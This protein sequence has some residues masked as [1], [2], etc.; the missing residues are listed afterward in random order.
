[1][2]VELSTAA[3]RAIRTNVGAL[4]LPGVEV[5]AEPVE[6]L[7]SRAPAAAFDVVFCDPPYVQGVAE[8]LEA[9]AG[10]GWLVP[11]AVVVVERATRDPQLSWPDGLEAVQARRYGD[12]T[13]WYGR[14]S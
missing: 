8:V 14:R 2:L 3:L 9:L 11:G 4:E 1:V 10:P 12:S 5:S 13:L 7:L 6:R